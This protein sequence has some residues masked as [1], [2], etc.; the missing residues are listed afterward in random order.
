MTTFSLVY[1]LPLLVFANTRGGLGEYDSM[2]HSISQPMPDVLRAFGLQVVE[3]DRR[4]SA[5]DWRDTFQEAGAPARM[6]YRPVAVVPGVAFDPTGRGE[7]S[8]RVSYA[9]FLEDV[10]EGML[11]L[12]SCAEHRGAEIHA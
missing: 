9:A 12:V 11:R 4:G 6:T 5:A 1:H 10:R 2:I 8:I 3:L 7:H